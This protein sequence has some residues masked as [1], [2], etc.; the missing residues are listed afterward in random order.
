MRTYAIHSLHQKLSHLA[1]HLQSIQCLC[2]FRKCTHRNRHVHT[3]DS[4]VLTKPLQSGAGKPHRRPVASN[5]QYIYFAV[6]SRQDRRTYYSTLTGT[7]SATLRSRP[8]YELLDGSFRR[9]ILPAKSR[10]TFSNTLITLLHDICQTPQLTE[11][12]R[13][14]VKRYTTAMVTT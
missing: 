2:F 9:E 14:L 12:L 8:Q 5:Y 10:I 7:S 1:S 11:P 4:D 3:K 6:P 13:K